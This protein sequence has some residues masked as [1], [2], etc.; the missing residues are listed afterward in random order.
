MPSPFPGMNP[1]LEQSARWK[2]FHQRFVTAAAEVIGAQ[3]LP[4]Y[5]VNLEA[6]IFI[7]PVEEGRQFVGVADV[8][9]S[10]PSE[11]P[12]SSRPTAVA[13]APAQVTL[14][15]PDARER[16]SYLEIRDRWTHRI[17]TVVEMLSPS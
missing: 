12:R 2:D 15:A 16:H 5:Y 13:E 7:H 10:S 14:P 3:V 4:R 11:P 17:V 9:V 8:G 6:D 1:Y